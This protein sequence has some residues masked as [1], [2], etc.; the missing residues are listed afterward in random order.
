MKSFL[1]IL[2]LLCLINLIN[3]QTRMR[4]KFTMKELNEGEMSVI[5]DFRAIN[6]NAKYSNELMSIAK[7][8][9][10]RLAG[11]GQLTPPSMKLLGNRNFL[12]Y[13]W[14]FTDLKPGK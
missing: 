2:G 3:A 9:A 5:N 13:S 4:H 7:N 14:I 11:Q 10:L 12:G 1:N 6:E 8:E